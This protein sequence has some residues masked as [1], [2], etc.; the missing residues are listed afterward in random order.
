MRP[1]IKYTYLYVFKHNFGLS[2]DVLTKNELVLLATPLNNNDYC[3][4]R[5]FIKQVRL[6]KQI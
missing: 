2:V 5:I 1:I 6:C 4:F 3:P